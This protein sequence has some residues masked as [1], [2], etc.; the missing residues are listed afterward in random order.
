M[1]RELMPLD[2]WSLNVPPESSLEEKVTVCEAPLSSVMD[3]RAIQQAATRGS[4]L[5]AVSSSITP[6]LG[7]KPMVLEFMVSL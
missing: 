4:T 1:F 2:S 6:W 5:A 7:V 3:E